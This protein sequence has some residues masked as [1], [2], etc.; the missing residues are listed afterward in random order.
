MLSCRAQREREKCSQKISL[1]FPFQERMP[2]G[3]KEFVKKKMH[4]DNALSKYLLMMMQEK[5]HFFFVLL[6]LSFVFTTD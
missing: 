2:R 1:F 4:I 6:Y 3:K 5:N